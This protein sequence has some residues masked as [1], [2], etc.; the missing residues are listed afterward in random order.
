M[1]WG[2]YYI[3]ISNKIFVRFHYFSSTYKQQSFHPWQM[4]TMD[5]RSEQFR[6]QM[7]NK[8]LIPNGR[9]ND[10]FD[11]NK[12]AWVIMNLF[13]FFY[14]KWNEKYFYTFVNIHSAHIYNIYNFICDIHIFLSI[15]TFN[16][17]NEWCAW[18]CIIMCVQ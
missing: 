3:M 17:W 12:F 7:R 8:W 14:Q 11:Y 13:C 4:D 18:W 6:Y 1:W 5:C 9:E 2:Y 16:T 15:F 10:T